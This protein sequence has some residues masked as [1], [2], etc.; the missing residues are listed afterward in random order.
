MFQK[1]QTNGASKRNNKE[2]KIIKV[3]LKGQLFDFFRTTIMNLENY[4][5]NC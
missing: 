2:P 5:E 1:S 3:K 4:L